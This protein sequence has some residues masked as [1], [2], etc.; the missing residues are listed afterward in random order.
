MLIAAN[1][2][3]DNIFD[4][5]YINPLHAELNSIYHFLAVLGTHPILHISGVSVNVYGTITMCVKL[6]E[7]TNK[8]QPRNRIY[9]SNVF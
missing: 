2:P 8:M 9:Y 1:H 5:F 3:L 4:C 7:R 6:T